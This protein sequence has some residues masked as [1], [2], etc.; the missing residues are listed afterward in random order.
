[1][2][3]PH[4]DPYTINV[5]VKAETFQDLE[6]IAK[7][8]TGWGALWAYLKIKFRQFRRWLGR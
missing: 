5:E 8:Q 4:D 1:M 2:L 6:S 7:A 3:D